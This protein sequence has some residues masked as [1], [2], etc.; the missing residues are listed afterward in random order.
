MSTCPEPR[1]SLGPSTFISSFCRRTRGALAFDLTCREIWTVDRQ[2]ADHEIPHDSDYDDYDNW[3][4]DGSRGP[5]DDIRDYVVTPYPHNK[6][7]ELNCNENEICVD[8]YRSVDDQ[9][10]S[11]AYCV[12]TDNFREIAAERVTD[13]DADIEGVTDVE[14]HSGKK[15]KGLEVVLTKPDHRSTMYAKRMRIQAQT[16]VDMYGTKVWRTMKEGRM[17]CKGC[18]KLE[19]RPV[20]PRTQRVHVDVML[21]AMDIG[22]G[23]FAYLINV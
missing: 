10:G 11:V 21:S 12:S 9:E 4:N 13:L 18:A 6:I 15:Q 19:L 23:G 3:I 5:D 8:G 14:G 16:A 7:Y 22:A 1:P 20:P 17:D 2:L